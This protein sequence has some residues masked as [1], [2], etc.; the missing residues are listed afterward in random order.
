MKISLAWLQDVAF[1]A[2]TEGGHRIVFDGP[3]T[4]TAEKIA[5]LAR[6]KAC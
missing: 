5:A 3:P 4:H 6:W 1:S 2:Q